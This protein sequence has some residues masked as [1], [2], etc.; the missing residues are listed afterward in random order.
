MK[1]YPANV[2]RAHGYFLRSLTLAEMSVLRS[3]VEEQAFWGLGQNNYCATLERNGLF[4]QLLNFYE[5]LSL[6]SPSG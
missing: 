1:D 3:S 5:L 2:G 4:R 6:R